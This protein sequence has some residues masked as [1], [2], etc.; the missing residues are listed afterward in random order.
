MLRSR[1]LIACLGF[2]VFNCIALDGSEARPAHRLAATSLLYEETGVASFYGD[3]LQ[4]HKTASGRRFDNQRFTA[5]SLTLP[6][7]SKAKVTSLKTGL[8][9]TVTII[10]RGPFAKARVID[11]SRA[12]A[13]EIGITARDGIGMVLVHPLRAAEANAHDRGLDIL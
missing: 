3:E 11:L 5:A 12:A 6:I 8:S 4:G 13:E 7:N 10:D 2:L 1:Y 9:V